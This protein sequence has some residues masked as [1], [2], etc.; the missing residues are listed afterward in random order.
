MSTLHRLAAAKPPTVIRRLT[1]NS[2][3]AAVLEF[4]LVAIPFFAVVFAALGTSL[5]YFA[6]QGL[7]SAAAS[8]GRSLLVGDTQTASPS[9]AQF[10]TSVCAKLPGYMRCPNLLV[11]VDRSVDFATVGTAS[12]TITF[13]SDGTPADSMPYNLGA[14]GD[15]VTLRLYYVWQLPSVNL[16][17]DIGNLSKGRRLLIATS[18]AQ[19]EQYS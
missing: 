9:K 8:A 3:G 4:A 17:Y 2:R 13:N 11:S 10:K 16:G 18:V 12:P 1:A 5:A 15:I 14:P 19:T 7:E 6:Q